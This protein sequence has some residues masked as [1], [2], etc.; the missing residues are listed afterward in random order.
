MIYSNQLTGKR[1]AVFL[2]CIF[3]SMSASMADNDYNQIVERTSLTSPD[4][5]QMKKFGTYPV[6]YSTGVP[7]IEIPLYEINLDGY[8]LPISIKYHA[9][10]IKV[11]EAPT[12]VGS[13]WSL[14]A[15]GCISR[16][17]NCRPDGAFTATNILY[18]YSHYYSHVSNLLFDDCLL[19]YR[20]HASGGYDLE[21]D[22][23][24]Y[25]FPGHSGAFRYSIT[26]S[27]FYTL[28]YEPIVIDG[29]TITD[30][31]GNV[32]SFNQ[33]EYTHH[34]DF[35]SW[36]SAWH[37]TTIKPYSSDNQITLSY[38][39]N[40]DTYEMWSFE[41]LENIIASDYGNRNLENSLHM[42]SNYSSIVKLSSIA[43]LG[44]S[45]TFTYMD[46]YLQT[47][48]VRNNQNKVVRFIQF[49]YYSSRP[50]LL[51]KITIK[52][53]SNST[54][55]EV[56]KFEYDSHDF[57][58]YRNGVTQTC[59]ED[60]WG[61]YNG[62]KS[63]QR[64]IPYEFSDD[65]YTS[66]NSNNWTVN[67]RAVD[68]TLCKAK[69]LTK[70]TYP[71]GGS[72]EFF[73]ESNRLDNG[74]LCGGLRLREYISKDR[75][76]KE[77]LRR[78]LSYSHAIPAVTFEESLYHYLIYHFEIVQLSLFPNQNP[79]DYYFHQYQSTPVL[80]LEGAIGS[81][82]Y[83]RDVKEYMGAMGN[84]KEYTQYLYHNENAN[85]TLGITFNPVGAAYRYLNFYLND[86]GTSPT[87]LTAKYVF[88]ANGDTLLQE[89][90]EYERYE[91]AQKSVGTKVK[92]LATFPLGGNGLTYPHYQNFLAEESCYMTP[93]VQ[94]LKKKTI[95]QDNV[96]T[97][98]EYTYDNDL[99]TLS[100]LSEKVTGSNGDKEETVYKYPFQ[101]TG[102]GDEGALYASMCSNNLQYPI[103][104]TRTNQSS[105]LSSTTVASSEKN[106][107]AVQSNG[108]IAL[109]QY[110]YS[111]SDST[112][113]R[114]QY[115]YYPNGKIK[116]LMQDSTLCTVFIWGYK[117]QYPVMKIEG[118]D[119]T[120][121]TFRWEAATNIGLIQFSNNPTLNETTLNT[122]R[123]AFESSQCLV[124]TYLFDPLTGM[125]RM[126]GPDG[127]EISYIYDAL[128]RLTETND[129]D[130]N[131][132]FYNEYNYAH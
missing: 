27:S 111:Q 59:Q 96:E 51:E 52:G 122:V 127:V 124:T 120:E 119:P 11:H 8:S 40:S 35:D 98:T 25:S 55:S 31:S 30:E 90:S 10:G 2:L 72:T 66:N 13:G 16:E 85:W 113:N 117:W 109:D 93:S 118:M 12:C 73:F 3:M 126:V 33:E 97:V 29:N 81:P 26:D 36:C 121:L 39:N 110:C 65:E 105:I 45:V 22:K 88:S 48:T 20:G 68:E 129:E 4:V 92:Q 50:D 57:N 18:D 71:T 91:L 74:T 43:W 125:T 41:E 67:N 62:L 77:L 7:N 32:F 101:L 28:P 70:I 69:S 123:H 89:L 102:S 44:N 94:L 104:I 49:S 79:N 61:Y 24:Y 106:Q 34:S 80:P 53:N 38:A 116:G 99:R 63:H 112:E 95:K 42:S 14:S 128:G 114:L 56:Y 6:D 82:V 46:N 58:R 83:Y 100:P 115:Y 87:L 17:V 78:T 54:L 5:A 60:Y 23:Y 37:L 131:P 75:D 107:Y 132:I 84:D 15:G 108:K 86:K 9:S 130:N 19:L 1:P 64:F 21:V 103:T 76:G 47:I